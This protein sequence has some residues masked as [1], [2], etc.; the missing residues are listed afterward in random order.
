MQVL[1]LLARGLS[2]R[3]I[4]AEMVIRAATVKTHVASVLMKLNVRDRARAIVGRAMP[5]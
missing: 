4:A 3:K 2:N 5:D 1:E